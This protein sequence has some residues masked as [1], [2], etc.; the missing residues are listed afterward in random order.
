MVSPLLLATKGGSALHCGS[1]VWGGGGGDLQ[2]WASGSHLGD[3]FQT[4]WSASHWPGTLCKVST[5]LFSA[6]RVGD[7]EES[8]K[9]HLQPSP[10][11]SFW[12]GAGHEAHSLAKMHSNLLLNSTLLNW[13]S[14]F[15]PDMQSVLQCQSRMSSCA[16]EEAPVS[17]S[18]SPVRQSDWRL[19]EKKGRRGDEREDGRCRRNKQWKI[20]MTSNDCYV[21]SAIFVSHL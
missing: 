7:N 1:C 17:M 14:F 10:C 21:E 16:V 20:A 9:N 19:A 12:A 15:S 5:F 4:V 11:S 8:K 18:T 13:F 6:G 3:H 2:S